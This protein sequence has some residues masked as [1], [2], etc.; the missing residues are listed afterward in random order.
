MGEVFSWRLVVAEGSSL[1]RRGTGVRGIATSGSA[2]Q[3]G[4]EPNLED[5]RHSEEMHWA[6]MRYTLQSP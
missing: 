5:R 2:I 6:A 3:E 4:R 1:P